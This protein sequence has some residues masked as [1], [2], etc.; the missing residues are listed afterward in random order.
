MASF[1][2]DI[3]SSKLYVYGFGLESLNL[4]IIMQKVKSQI[5]NLLY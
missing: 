4:L 1:G 2:L 5:V 3:N